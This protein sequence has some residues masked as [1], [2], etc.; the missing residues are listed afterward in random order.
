MLYTQEYKIPLPFSLCCYGRLCALNYMA[1]GPYFL[2]LSGP[3]YRGI[4]EKVK[5]IYIF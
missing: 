2:I 4:V 5:K 1:P 3:I